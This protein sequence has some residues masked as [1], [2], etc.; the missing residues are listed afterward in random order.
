MF[1]TV[2]VIPCTAGMAI[3]W[4]GKACNHRMKVRPGG[5]AEASLIKRYAEQNN[6]TVQEIV[7]GM[8][9]CVNCE[10]IIMGHGA[11]PVSPFKRKR[12]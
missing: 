2:V 7:A 12:I 3:A 4:L 5:H 9:V 6:M 10:K 11:K 8:P 1:D